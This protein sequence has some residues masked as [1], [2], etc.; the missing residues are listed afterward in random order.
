MHRVI[1]DTDFE[2]NELRRLRGLFRNDSQL[3]SI[4]REQPGFKKINRSTIH[5]WCADVGLRLPRRALRA[6][7]ILKGALFEKTSAVVTR[8]RIAHH[9][10]EL[11]TSAFLA[12][13]PRL[14][15]KRGDQTLLAAYN[16]CAEHV[17]TGNGIES[18][19]RLAAKE[20]DIAL[21]HAGL[22]KSPHVGK[23]CRQLCLISRALA[24]AV[25]S[26]PVTNPYD[27]REMKFGFP[28]D[29]FIE[30][31]I[32]ETLMRLGFSSDMAAT[33][34]QQCDTPH[35]AAKLFQAGNID[36][37]IAWRKWIDAARE[38]IDRK[39]FDV[40]GSFFPTTEF[41]AYV[42][43]ECADA[44]GVRAFLAAV[45]EVTR[46]L[47]ESLGRQE[48]TRVLSQV[49]AVEFHDHFGMPSSKVRQNIMDRSATFVLEEFDPETVLDLWQVEALHAAVLGGQKEKT[50]E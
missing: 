21:A 38:K 26:R 2:R 44:T 36:C 39:C 29:T 7:Q 19:D 35:H 46:E 17:R 23:G 37:I 42:N 18:L 40:H 15:A 43:L 30:S 32:S 5:R 33:A 41:A 47:S 10:T 9:I 4:L 28:R 50:H 13:A 8:L 45:R 49:P 16:A 24:S 3:V 11:A 48:L 20:A 22:L 6:I 1:Y 34:V 25:A 12:Y 14:K 31:S 27:L